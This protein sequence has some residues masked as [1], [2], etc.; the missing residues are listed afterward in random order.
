MS[1][2]RSTELLIA[3]DER[4][5]LCA[6]KVALAEIFMTVSSDWSRFLHEICAYNPKGETLMHICG[7]SGN[8]CATNLFVN[9][10]AGK[11]CWEDSGEALVTKAASLMFYSQGW[12]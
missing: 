3:E 5:A 10:F 12:L 8:A 9:V 7:E 6:I 2:I 4:K 1:N 11:R